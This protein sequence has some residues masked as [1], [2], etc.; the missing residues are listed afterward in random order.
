MRKILHPG[1]RTITLFS[2]AWRRYPGKR[3]V[4]IST[5]DRSEDSCL[6][7]SR[8][9]FIRLFTYKI[10]HADPP[11]LVPRRLADIARENFGVRCERPF[12]LFTDTQEALEK[13][14]WFY[15]HNILPLV[16]EANNLAVASFTARRYGINAMVSELPIAAEFMGRLARECD[17]SCITS[18]TLIGRHFTVAEIEPFA[19]GGRRVR[20]LLG[21]PTLG[22]FAESCSERLVAGELVFHP[23]ATSAVELDGGALR[24]TKTIEL[25]QPVRRQATGITATAR[26]NCP[27]G[28]AVAFS[29]ASWPG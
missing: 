14:L 11:L 21:L 29:L 18:L 19:V 12:V 9:S 25:L 27:C 16:G 3:S 13:S 22:A 15:A 2:I 20:A 6:C 17:T 4:W 7:N 24:V 28:A 23:D 5:R 1:K 10:V 26:S 8:T